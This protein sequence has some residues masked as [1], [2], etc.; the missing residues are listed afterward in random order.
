M[1]GT[2]ITLAA[3]GASSLA[4]FKLADWLETLLPPAEPGRLTDHQISAI[5]AAVTPTIKDKK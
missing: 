3:L 5:L 4:L 1:I 2:Y